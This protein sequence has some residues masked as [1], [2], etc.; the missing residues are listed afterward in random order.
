MIYVIEVDHLRFPLDI[1]L[2]RKFVHAHAHRSTKIPIFPI[3]QAFQE[4]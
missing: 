3:L 2:M 4:C 1:L